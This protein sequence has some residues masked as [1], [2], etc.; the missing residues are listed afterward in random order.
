MCGESGNPEKRKGRKVRVALRRNRQKPG[1]VKDWTRKA[2]E[3]VDHEFDTSAGE[4]VVAKG[5]LSRNRTVRVTDGEAT[6]PGARH[7]VVVALRGLYA[8]VDDGSQLCLCTVRRML[9]T[10]LINERHPI[11]VG[12]RVT[13]VGEDPEDPRCATGVIEAVAPRGGQLRR[14]A[15]RRVQ[16]IVA[17]VDQAVIVSSAA[18][19]LPKP[20]LIDR[21]IV[22]A[23]AG[24]ITPLVCMNKMDLAED[25]SAG[26]IL[27]RYE[28]LGYQTVDT[29]ALTGDGID[30]L[31]AAL[32][33]KA[34][35]I[36][37]QSGVGKSSLL[38]AVQPGLALEVGDIAAHNE[39]GRHT[40]TTAH[41]IRL[42]QGGYVV[43][44][45]GIRSFDLSLIPRGEFEGYFAEFVPLVP[46]CRF[47]DCTHTHESDC[48][49]K[50]A[51]EAGAVHPER[52]E[53]YL[54]LFLE[55]P[56]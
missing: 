3:G 51:V 46:H 32:K 25:E 22:S 48:A 38:N 30:R 11:T 47:P 10:R 8:H 17:N 37:G 54:H 41:L 2:R 12:D 13:F 7:G 1:R 35:V 42:H 31:R 15:G 43:D 33:D 52:Y 29:S 36:V 21:Y 24:D 16:T 19:P 27:K 23:L 40:T 28:S 44:T 6:V 26:R 55:P 4:S 53:S 45:P 20:Q 56:S 18:C 5:D 34:S 50:A 49:I 9:R 39:K 14:R